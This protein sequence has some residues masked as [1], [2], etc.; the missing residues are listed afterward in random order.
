MLRLLDR[1]VSGARFLV[2][3]VLECHNSNRRSVAVSCMLY[4]IRS[5]HN[6]PIYSTMLFHFVPVRVTSSALVVHRHSYAFPRCRTSHYRT[7]STPSSVSLWNVLADSVYVFD[8]VR[9]VGFK[10]WVIDFS[11]NELCVENGPLSKRASTQ[12]K[13]KVN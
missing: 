2:D 10:S 5:N 11:K 3:G 12:Y 13:I 6:H 1:V 9:L 4:K 7:T 8:G